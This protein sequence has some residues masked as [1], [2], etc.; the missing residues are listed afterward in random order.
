MTSEVRPLPAW[1][2]TGCCLIWF[3]FKESSFM[4][5]R[6]L[7]GSH[8]RFLCHLHSLEAEVKQKDMMETFIPGTGRQ[9]DVSGLQSSVNI[10]ILET[11]YHHTP[12]FKSDSFY[13]KVLAVLIRISARALRA[14]APWENPPKHTQCM[15]SGTWQPVCLWARPS[16]AVGRLS[17]V[18]F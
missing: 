3:L 15:C 10:I 17:T 5:W 12:L 2:W 6:R 8:A 9:G 7:P 18:F 14:A 11:S 13:R 16:G 1:L 4:M